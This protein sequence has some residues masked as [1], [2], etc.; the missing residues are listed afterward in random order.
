MRRD[1]LWLMC[2]CTGEE[3]VF[4]YDSCCS[5]MLNCS[6]GGRI[7]RAGMTPR[8]LKEIFIQVVGKCQFYN[9]VVQE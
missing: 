5:P 1:I 9:S 3:L 2:I 6:I 8:P 4:V 7:C